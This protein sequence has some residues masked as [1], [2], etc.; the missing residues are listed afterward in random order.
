MPEPALTPPR[1]HVTPSEGRPPPPAAF[2]ELGL[3]TCFSFLRGASDARDLILAAQALG[4]DALGIA[5]ANTLAG[6][7]RLHT[8]AEAV[9]IRPIIGCRIETVEG[10]A[11]LA[12]P[13]DRGAYGRLCRLISTGRMQTLTG[14]WQAKGVCQIDLAMLAEHAE[15]LRLVLVP[16]ADLDQ[17]FALETESNVYAFLRG[18]AAVAPPVSN[19]ISLSFP[20]LLPRLVH[21]LP[22]MRHV[23]ASYLYVG[24]DIARIERL[25][26]L[27]RSSGLGLLATNEV[28]YATPAR[29]PLQ[30]VMTAI[31]HKT[32]VA[33]A[34]HLLE[35]NAER[36]LKSPEEMVRLFER[37][38]DAIAATRQVADSCRFN[39]REL[40]YE[41]PE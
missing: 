18:E 33:K 23:A 32:T 12:Y 19:S 39:L 25:N 2:V 31:R 11:F 14:E 16:P 20:D 5:D 3:A 10:L 36:H 8:D 30:D 28:L 26:A 35:P 17:T 7:V 24:D 21:S 41:Y 27:A 38:P 9:N 6:V 22:S 4:Y 29:R 15:G 1:R 37:W 13:Q 34:G 40:R